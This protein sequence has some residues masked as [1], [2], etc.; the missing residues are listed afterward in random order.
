MLVGIA[1]ILIGVFAVLPKAVGITLRGRYGDTPCKFSQI[2]KQNQNL[3]IRLCL[4]SVKNMRFIKS[5]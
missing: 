4:R 3:E 2:R 1:F 5:Q